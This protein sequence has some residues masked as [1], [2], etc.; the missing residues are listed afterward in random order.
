MTLNEITQEFA[1]HY[2]HRFL[3]KDI[4][5][6]PFR[7]ESRELL[8]KVIFEAPVTAAISIGGRPEEGY[9]LSCPVCGIIQLGGFI[10]PTDTTLD[11]TK[12]TEEKRNI[13][14]GL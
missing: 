3:G 8:G 12:T 6:V 5:K 2:G 7:N 10:S 4:A 9:F 1:C 14:L 11:K 13:V